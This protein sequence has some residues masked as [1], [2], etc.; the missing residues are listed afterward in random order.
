VQTVCIWCA[1]GGAFTGQILDKDWTFTGQRLGQ[2]RRER[3]TRLQKDYNLTTLRLQKD[4]RPAPGVGELRGLTGGLALKLSA[5][6]EGI[7]QLQRL[8][9]LL[10]RE[11]LELLEPSLKAAIA[12][13]LHAAQGREAEQLVG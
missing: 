2:D 4:D 8:A 6:D 13:L 9:L 3:G 10:G 7:E 1:L 11:L 12:R 5:L